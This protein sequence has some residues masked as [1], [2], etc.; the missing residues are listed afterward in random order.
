MITV[1]DGDIAEDVVA[2][3]AGTYTVSA[4]V[5]PSG[6]LIVDHAG[7][8]D[9]TYVYVDVDGTHSQPVALPAAIAAGNLNDVAAKQHPGK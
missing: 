8:R 4:P 3:Y 5:S 9:Q 2:G 6:R 1:P 7:H